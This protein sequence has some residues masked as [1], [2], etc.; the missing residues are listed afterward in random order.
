MPS[1]SEARADPALA[2]LLC[3]SVYSTE[4][5]F[6]QLYRP[7]LAELGLTYPQYLVM[8][9]LWA[10]DG[11][12]VRELGRALHLQSNTLTPLLK[13]LE[14]LGLLSRR[15]DSDDERVVRVAL[16]AGGRAL[17]EKARDIP[18]CVAEATGMSP[19]ELEKAIAL[20]NRLRENLLEKSAADDAAAAR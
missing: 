10:R 8:T 17:R 13:R 20:V 3:F 6:S 9:L 1:R 19:T 15:R 7:L 11:R 16:M 4:H 2:D 5:A 18:A 12:T 14:T